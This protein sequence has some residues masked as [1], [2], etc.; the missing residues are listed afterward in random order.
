MPVC[1]CVC[2]C[3]CVRACVCVCVCVRVCVCVCVCVCVRAC[4][5]AGV[6]ACV[7]ARAR[8]RARV[9]VC[10]CVCVCVLRIVSMDKIL[11][12]TDTL[13]IAIICSSMHSTAN[14]SVGTETEVWPGQPHTLITRPTNM[15]SFKLHSA[16]HNARTGIKELQ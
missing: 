5:R 8:A 2:V 16:L 12:F 6:R 9:C 10:V 4:V 7:R 11:S 14:A 15:A 13:I 1:V 3:V